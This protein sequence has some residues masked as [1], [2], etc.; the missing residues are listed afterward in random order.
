MQLYYTHNELIPTC[1][2]VLFVGRFSN[3]IQPDLVGHLQ[4]DFCNVC[5]VC[6]NLTI[7]NFHIRLKSV[8]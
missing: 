8:L 5:S 3:M 4:G 7:K 6:F 1:C 2:T